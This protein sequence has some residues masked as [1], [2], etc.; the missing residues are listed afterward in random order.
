MD[1]RVNCRVIFAN[2]PWILLVFARL[3]FY[4]RV[5][6]ELFSSI[7]FVSRCRHILQNR[8]NY[9]VC[10]LLLMF[11]L[12]HF[13]FIHFCLCL[14]FGFVDSEWKKKML[15]KHVHCTHTLMTQE[16]KSQCAS[17]QRFTTIRKIERNSTQVNQLHARFTHLRQFYFC[18]C[19]QC[20]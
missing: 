15:L 7:L 19:S 18:T 4:C 8:I 3:Q 1:S 10:A 17:L 14:T 9:T 16:G 5:R 12:V 2:L 13:R 6:V 20:H 11:S